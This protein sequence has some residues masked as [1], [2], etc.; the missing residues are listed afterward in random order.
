MGDVLS[1]TTVTQQ[2]KD[3]L[4]QLAAQVVDEDSSEEMAQLGGEG[5][6]QLQVASFKAMSD[7]DALVEK[8]RRR[9]HR[10]YRQAANVPG[11][12]LWHRVRIGPFQYKYQAERYQDSFEETERMSTF[13]VDPEKVK[14][15]KAIRDAKLAA[16][17][18]KR[19]R[20]ARHTED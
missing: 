7:A 9:G 3:S 2:P 18:K 8:L 20:A 1:S 14:R 16:R 5:G 10:A 6:Y 4:T 12:G 13:L 17:E 15:Q 19:K 11:R